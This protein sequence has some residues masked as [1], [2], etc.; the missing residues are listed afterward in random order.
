MEVGANLTPYSGIIFWGVILTP[1]R[2]LKDSFSGVKMTP[3]IEEL[4]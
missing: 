2:S 3:G 4:K 1:K